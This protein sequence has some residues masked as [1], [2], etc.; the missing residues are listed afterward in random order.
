MHVEKSSDLQRDEGRGFEGR[1]EGLQGNPTPTASHPSP[2]AP[3][4]SH[5]SE[6][7]QEFFERTGLIPEGCLPLGDHFTSAIASHLR[8]VT[9][10]VFAV[11]ES[12]DRNE[13]LACDGTPPISHVKA[14]SS[15]SVRKDDESIAVVVSCEPGGLVTYK[16]RIQPR[17][18]EIGYC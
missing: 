14:P 9:P 5:R 12:Q 15:D 11:Q 4:P 10:G 13:P 16:P 8:E 6:T 1:R 2:S 18:D 7:P 17:P 3:V